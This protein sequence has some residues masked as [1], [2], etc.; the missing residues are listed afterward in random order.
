M[1]LVDGH[2]LAY[3]YLLSNEPKIISF[4]LG[5]G[6]GTS[7]LELISIFRHVNNC[8]INY[9]FVE[10]R[11]GD[12]AICYA[13]NSKAKNFLNWTPKRC[14]EEMCQDGW[15]WYKNNL[16]AKVIYWILKLLSH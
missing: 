7:V 10:K 6:F 12:V 9:K 3:E 4:N 14:I 1:D 11:A 8:D 13:D 15:E 5:T 2:I 16:K